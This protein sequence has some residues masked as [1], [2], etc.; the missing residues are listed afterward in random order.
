M[1]RGGQCVPWVLSTPI[2]PADRGERE[3]EE[4]EGATATEIESKDGVKEGRKDGTIV[5][6]CVC[7][8]DVRVC[9]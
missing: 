3:R 5:C 2:Q 9:V 4:R 7:V 8:C 6:I 1:G